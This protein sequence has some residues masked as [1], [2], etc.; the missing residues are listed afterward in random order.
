[1]IRACLVMALLAW[2]SMPVGAKNLPLADGLR[3]CAGESDEA[4]RLAC[5]DALVKHASKG[6]SR[7]VRLDRGH[8]TQARSGG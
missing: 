5:F 8:R 3:R 1:M 7:P 2:V 6:R 4:K